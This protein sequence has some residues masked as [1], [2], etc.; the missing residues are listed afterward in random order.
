MQPAGVWPVVRALVH[1]F[2]VVGASP[3][4]QGTAPH[5]KARG[6]RGAGGFC[7]RHDTTQ[8]PGGRIRN[9]LGQ[10]QTC[11]PPNIPAGALPAIARAGQGRPS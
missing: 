2:C 6:A 7:P 5:S 3:N 1:M 9:R 4:T 11:C 8:H 10:N